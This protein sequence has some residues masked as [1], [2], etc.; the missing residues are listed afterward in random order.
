FMVALVLSLALHESSQRAISSGLRDHLDRVQ[1]R[2]SL[3]PVV[4]V[5]PIGTLLFPAIMFC[6]GVPLSGWAKPTPVNPL[7]W[8]NKRVANFWVSAAGA[9]SNFIIA[10]IAGVIIR[11]L[12]STGVIDDS[13]GLVNAGSTIANGAL[14]L[15]IVFFILNVA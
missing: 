3:N 10:I 5:H 14:E 13:L 2:T 8:R 1:G 15:L 7:K 6:T 9:L 4:H 11:L 12:Y